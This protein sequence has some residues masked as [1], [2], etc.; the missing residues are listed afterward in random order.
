MQVL[1][2]RRRLGKA[3]IVIGMNAGSRVL[4]SA[5]VR[6]PA[7][8]SSLTNRSWNVLCA[9]ET[10]P[11]AWLESAQMMSMVQS[12]QSAPK[13]GHPVAA[14]RAG[15]VVPNTPCLSL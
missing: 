15:L 14:D 2:V 12:M 13:L 8:R 5:R 11:L 4:P 9:R 6:T 7:S 1:L 3:C 10:R